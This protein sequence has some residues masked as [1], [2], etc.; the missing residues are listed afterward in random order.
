VK[1]VLQ[2]P[3]QARSQETPSANE[4]ALQLP[5]LLSN[6]LTEVILACVTKSKDDKLLQK[7]ISFI[8]LILPID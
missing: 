8:L 5:Q 2:L 6:R 1:K 7:S 3:I 4:I